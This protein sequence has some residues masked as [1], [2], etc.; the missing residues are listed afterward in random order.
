MAQRSARNRASCCLLALLL[1]VL[2]GIELHGIDLGGVRIRLQSVQY[3]S[4]W[5]FTVLTYRVKQLV[6]PPASYWVLGA[7]D[8]ITNSHISPYSTWFEWTDSPF[9]GFRFALDSANRYVYVV[10][11]GRW[12]V[13]PTPVAVIR[14]GPGYDP[15]VYIDSIDGPACAGSSI[16]LQVINGSQVSFPDP[17]GADTYEAD[18]QTTLR[19]SSTSQ[20]WTLGHV[21]SLSIPEGASQETVSS[22]FHVQYDPFLAAAGTTELGVSY[23]LVIDEE[24][25]AGLPQG[26]YTI[27]ITFT[28]TT[29]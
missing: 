9:R 21:V 15:E 4:Y 16:S 11:Y 20:G 12:D 23:S 17:I 7:G 25:F 2:V 8:C 6:N 13:A 24:D 1:V 14:T 10:L 19:V 3:Y 18:E 26:I 28:A 29:D 5:D 27:T 22:I